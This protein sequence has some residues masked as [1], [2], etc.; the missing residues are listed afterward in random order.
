MDV[1][2]DKKIKIKK[3][4]VDKSEKP[5]KTVKSKKSKNASLK[6]LDIEEI[7]K[8]KNI[9]IINKINNEDS[10]N[11]KDNGDLEGEDL[12]AEFAKML[13]DIKNTPTVPKNNFNG[14]KYTLPID[15]VYQIIKR[16]DS[17]NGPYGTQWIHDE[18]QLDDIITPKEER[19]QK[20]LKDLMAIEYPEQRSEAW[21]KLRDGKITASD[22]GT[23]IGCNKHEPQFKFIMKKVF[24]APFNNNEFCYHGKKYERIATS[25][26]EY[27]MNLTT[28]EFGLVGHPKYSFLG[29]SPDGIVGMY[30]MDGKHLTK[31]VGR[32]LEI[33]CPLIR[34]IKMEGEILDHIVPIYYWVQVQLQL[35]CCDLDECDFW[36]CELSEYKSREEF[37]QD[38]DPVEPFRSRKSGFEKGCVIQLIPHSRYNDVKDGK[39]YDVIYDCASFIYPPKI[40]M[41]PN[42]IDR[43]IVE[44]YEKVRN[45]PQYK[46]V[47]IDKVIYW[48][49]DKSNST[50]LLRD[51]KWFA[52]NLPTYDKMW[53]Y[54][55][56]YRANEDKRNE[57]KEYIESLKMKS[58]AKIM[59]YISDHYD[60]N[61]K[62]MNKYKDDKEI[63][64][65]AE[66]FMHYKDVV[67]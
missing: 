56:F 37:I 40:E 59:K 52:E 20:V 14:E 34:K 48:R 2:K 30:K 44:T 10:V 33:K 67:A 5:E 6:G 19:L 36:Q 38:T 65:N 64:A 25:I 62:D 1:L 7:D 28:I 50:T 58:N 16:N 63:V 4:K 61:I 21:Y 66:S 12:E 39:Y 29:A 53:K 3:D 60:N 35:Q 47:Y 51:D 18:P 45:D 9:E 27:R 32:M 8:T 23:V 13:D 31:Y 54:V 42:D 26:Y 43:W 55:E 46:D 41:S 17:T 57:L 24:G 22:G 49:L 11:D 15:K